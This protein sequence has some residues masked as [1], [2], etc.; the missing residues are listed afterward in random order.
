MVIVVFPGL[1]PL[2]AVGPHEVF[3]GANQ[4]LSPDQRYEIEIVAHRPGPVAG[5]SGLVL[6]AQGLGA[7]EG[8]GTLLLVGGGGVLEASADDVRAKMRELLPIAKAQ[9]MSEL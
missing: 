4:G 7:T 3:A 5:E 8:I 9:L 2:D 6:H 1:Q